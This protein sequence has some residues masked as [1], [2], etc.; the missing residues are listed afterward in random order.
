MRQGTTPTHTFTLSISVDMIKT[1]EITYEQGDKVVL[2]K[3][4]ADVEMEGKKVRLHLTQ[5]DT[6][7]LEASK[8][9]NVQLR[10]L[11]FDGSVPEMPIFTMRIGRSLSQEV[12][13]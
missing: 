2:T 13:T 4:T 11:L 6:F 1:V 10:I 8:L 3:H 9:I 7:A 12:L 5:E